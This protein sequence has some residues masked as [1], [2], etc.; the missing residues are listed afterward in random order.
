MLLAAELLKLVDFGTDVQVAV[1]FYQ[2]AK[3]VLAGLVTTFLVLPT[4][5][6]LLFY[7]VLAPG[8]KFSRMREGRERMENPS[9][10]KAG[11]FRDH[12]GQLGNIVGAGAK[13]PNMR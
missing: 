5:A 13:S 1:L 3:S 7:T 9:T 6:R 4:L 10:A 12:L 11:T 2:R 8:G